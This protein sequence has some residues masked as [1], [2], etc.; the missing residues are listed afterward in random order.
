M[1]ERKT[2][3][4]LIPRDLWGPAAA[5]VNHPLN[6]SYR[7][8]IEG[9]NALRIGLD[10]PSKVP[11]RLITFGRDPRCS[12]VILLDRATSMEQC[13][14][15]RNEKSQAILLRDTSGWG[16]TFLSVS[17]IHRNIRYRY[18]LQGNPKQRVLLP[19]RKIMLVICTAIFDLIWPQSSDEDNSVGETHRAPEQRQSAPELGWT[20]LISTRPRGCPYEIKSTHTPELGETARIDDHAR[21]N[22]LGQGNYGV[23][24]RTLDLETG[25]VWAVKTI[26]VRM[27]DVQFR[28]ILRRG[29]DL[30]ATL[31]H[32]HIVRLVHS[33]GW[34]IGTKVEI[35]M[36]AHEGSLED[37]IPVHDCEGTLPPE[38][39]Y[40]RTMV[41]EMLS[42]I[43]FIHAKDVIHRDIWPGNI[44][45]A[46]HENQPSP[47]KVHG[48][49]LYLA[50]EID[51]EQPITVKVDLWSFGILCLEV[52]GYWCEVDAQLT[53]DQW[54]A[55]LN[56]LS[57]ENTSR[58]LTP[59]DPESPNENGFWEDH[60]YFYDRI[61][62]LLQL[63]FVPE[64]L[65]Q[66]LVE[67]AE[68]RLSAQEYLDQ[69]FPSTAETSRS[70]SRTFPH[71]MMPEVP[72]DEP[73]A[74]AQAAQAVL[75]TPTRGRGKRK[76]RKSTSSPDQPP[77]ARLR[78]KPL[79]PAPPQLPSPE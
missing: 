56:S 61:R 52:L 53:L 9:V 49:F 11:G 37:L 72:D 57:P 19:D 7:K 31:Q 76:H 16:N 77:E 12:D 29:V 15:F 46:I 66:L 69:E 27:D 21:L 65:K 34:E 59:P 44:L 32:E 70:A 36:S 18:W 39:D 55:R 74:P 1:D 51:R 71:D 42:A 30:L 43:A 75:A 14:F 63:S 40:Y 2:L 54:R 4:W 67:D 38:P 8:E 33:K 68:E 73:P 25:N 78:L 3:F 60:N 23:V 41:H 47:R 5:I 26:N 24:Y 62:V 58:L 17:T 35:F 6:D 64:P 50:P 28:R 45:L 79:R 20:T 22:I 10:M 13:F 48:T